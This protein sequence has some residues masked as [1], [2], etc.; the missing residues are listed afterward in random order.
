[1]SLYAPIALCFILYTAAFLVMLLLMPGIKLRHQLQA[2]LLGVAAVLPIAFC[3]YI[4]L[5]LP[6]F[7]AHTFVSV[8]ITAI[9]FNGLIEETLKM[10]FMLPLP[11][12]KLELPFFLAASVLCGLTLGSFESV[13]Y[14][15]HRL[16]LIGMESARAALMLITVR[17]FTSVLVHAFC[18]GLS[19]L[20]IWA[21]RRGRT[22]YT[23]FILAALLHGLYNFFAGFSTGYRYFS[24]VVIIFAAIKCRVWYKKLTTEE[25]SS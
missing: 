20:F 25:T 24:F 13:I 17:M 21:Y 6:V 5:G 8:M 2:S 11:A 14:F 3:E 7:T 12:K 4:I 15:L 19:G 18:A 1:M 16:Q 22:A 23:P 9:I 10:I